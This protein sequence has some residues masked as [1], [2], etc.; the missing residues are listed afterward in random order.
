MRAIAERIARDALDLQE[1]GVSVIAVMPNDYV[2][3][4]DDAQQMR[5][6]ARGTTSPSPTSST[7]HRRWPTTRSAPPSSSA[8]TPPWLEPY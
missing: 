2:R 5:R 7:R 6:F 4:S 1:G 3:Y 8:S